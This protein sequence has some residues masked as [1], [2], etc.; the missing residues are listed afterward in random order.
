[1]P[2]SANLAG[3]AIYAV[4]G[5]YPITLWRGGDTTVVGV[6][7]KWATSIEAVVASEPGVTPAA[8][9]E[10]PADNAPSTATVK[11][12]LFD[13][14]S[15]SGGADGV[16]ATDEEAIEGLTATEQTISIAAP[17]GD[18]VAPVVYVFRLWAENLTGTN[19]VRI[20]SIKAV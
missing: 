8:D 20:N 2:L 12:R 3:N 17:T 9:G 11:V 7:P 15:T 1:M 5:G 13:A 6:V 16:A 14:P 18:G 19:G 10:D 4:P